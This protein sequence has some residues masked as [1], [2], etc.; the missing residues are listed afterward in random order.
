MSGES[1]TRAAAVTAN[2]LSQAIISAVVDEHTLDTD[3][4][5]TRFRVTKRARHARA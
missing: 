4:G 5:V 3:D 1:A 2:E